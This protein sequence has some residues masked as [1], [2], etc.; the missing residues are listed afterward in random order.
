MPMFPDIEEANREKAAA[1]DEVLKHSQEV[2]EADRAWRRAWRIG[3]ED[4]ARAAD[5]RMDKAIVL[6]DLALE[7]LNKARALLD[8]LPMPQD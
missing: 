4:E 1:W 2:I 8:H 5:A 7:R 6:R 3:Q